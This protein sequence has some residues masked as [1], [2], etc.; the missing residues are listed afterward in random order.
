MNNLKA[1]FPYFV[2]CSDCLK[3]DQ[4]SKHVTKFNESTGR[5]FQSFKC[6][7]LNAPFGMHLKEHEQC[8]VS[9]LCSRVKMSWSGW[10]SAPSKKALSSCSLA[11][12]FSPWQRSSC[13]TKYSS[14]A[15]STCGRTASISS[16]FLNQFTCTRPTQNNNT[17]K[18]WNA[19]KDSFYS[20]QG[21]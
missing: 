5:T 3:D 10:F 8:A 9:D 4:I 14:T 15:S 11:W 18:I 7:S 21:C 6:I 19:G 16:R 17:L 1:T 12:R 2:V 20:L 13:R